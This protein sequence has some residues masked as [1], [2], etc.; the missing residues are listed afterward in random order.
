MQ[1]I[2]QQF[3]ETWIKVYFPSLL[4]RKKW[5][6]KECDLRVGDICVLQDSNQVRG[7]FRRCRVSEVFPDKKGTIRNVEVLVANH[8]DGSRSYHP[9]ALRRLRRHV[10]NLIVIAPIEDFQDEAEETKEWESPQEVLAG[11]VKAVS[12][13]RPTLQNSAVNQTQS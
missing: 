2:I 9:Q 1:K 3:W 13:D 5:H 7:Q 8:Q 11:S 10:N 4:V 6:H 12:F